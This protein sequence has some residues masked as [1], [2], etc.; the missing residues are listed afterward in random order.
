MNVSKTYNKKDYA[1]LEKTGHIPK[2]AEYRQRIYDEVKGRIDRGNEMSRKFG[3]PEWEGILYEERIL[4]GCKIQAYREA[5][6]RITE[7][8]KGTTNELY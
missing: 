7:R 8:A 6:Q 2:T 1:I 4:Q 3:I 5:V